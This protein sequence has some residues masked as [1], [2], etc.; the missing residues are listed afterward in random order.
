MKI[1]FDGKE[2]PVDNENDNI[3]QIAEKNGVTIIAPCFRNEGKYG[4]CGACLIEVDGKRVFACGTKPY[5][6]M[7]IIYDSK[8]LEKMRQER[9]TEYANNIKAGTIENNSCSKYP[10][11]GCS[12]NCGCGGNCGC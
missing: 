3:V 10:D 4:G 1:I 2:M 11:G 5:D 9:L 7:K 6:G 8:E 12:S